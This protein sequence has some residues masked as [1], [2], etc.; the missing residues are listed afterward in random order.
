MVVVIALDRE[1]GLRPVALTG[2]AL[3]GSP[4]AALRCSFVT[5]LHVASMTR[6]VEQ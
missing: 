3:L 4:P 6:V 2:G 5:E 1:R